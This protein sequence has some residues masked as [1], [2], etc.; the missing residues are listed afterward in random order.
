MLAY[1]GQR[2]CSQAFINHCH[3]V[4]VQMTQQILC[5]WHSYIW[6]VASWLHVFSFRRLSWRH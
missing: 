3:L 1:H 6:R 5:V 2:L 4:A